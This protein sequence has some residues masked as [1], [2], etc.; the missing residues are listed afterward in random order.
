[1]LFCGLCDR[2]M[3]GTWTH[4]APYYRC[5]FPNEYALANH[6][7]HPRNV[8][9]RERDIL[10]TLDRWLAQALAPDRLDDTIT[11]MIAA[12]QQP[13]DNPAA[14]RARAAITGCDQK[15]ARYRAALDAGADPETVTTWIQQTTTDRQRAEADL[16]TIATTT[17]RPALTRDQLRDLLTQ[18]T[19]P[20]TTLRNADPADKASIYAGLGI[21]LI[22]QPATRTVHANAKLNPQPVG[23]R[24][25]SEDRPEPISDAH[26]H[27]RPAARHLR[28]SGWIRC[29]ATAV[30]STAATKAR[31]RRFGP[32]A[33]AG[34]ELRR[35]VRLK[36]RV[37]LAG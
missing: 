20:V 3:Q 33:G 17:A 24:F 15:L 26:H 27:R 13:S 11:A 30:R 22:Y 5:R 9:L 4:G 37:A 28:Q 8:Y 21:Q 10:P 31:P 36:R 1:V 25:V 2:R 32:W 29:C 12:D 34:T 35:R 19:E 6:V 16:R 23:R 14:D 18:I 7:A